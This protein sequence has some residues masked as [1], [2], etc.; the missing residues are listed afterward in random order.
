MKLDLQTPDISYLLKA[1]KKYLH[2]LE[3]YKEDTEPLYKFWC[4]SFVNFLETTKKIGCFKDLF[5]NTKILDDFFLDYYRR[6]YVSLN[7][8]WIIGFEF[9][10]TYP[11]KA[12]YC[13]SIQEY[14]S[15][16]LPKETKDELILVSQFASVLE[17]ILMQ[18]LFDIKAMDMESFIKLVDQNKKL[19][20]G[21][22]L[23]AFISGIARYYQVNNVNL[24]K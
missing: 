21:S 6:I 2:I 8:A 24:P 1:S 16:F 15:E 4:N 7:V 12:H 19:S 13:I 11:Q 17:L 10:E 22:M 20:R 14:D 18:K 9:A 23:T 5:P 3:K